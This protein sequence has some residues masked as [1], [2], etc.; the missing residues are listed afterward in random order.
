MSV[1]TERAYNPGYAMEIDR[2]NTFDN[3]YSNS[4]RTKEK[5]A[6]AGFFYTGRFILQRLVP[7]QRRVRRGWLLLHR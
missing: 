3:F 7:H 2:L 6:E 5:F 4:C 1:M